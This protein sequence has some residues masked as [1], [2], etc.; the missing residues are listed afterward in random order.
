MTLKS[1]LCSKKGYIFTYEAVAVVILFVAVFYMGYFT[2]THVNLTNQEQKRDLE[3]FEKANL[4]SDMIF[5]DY[6]F[7]SEYYRDDYHEFLEDVAVRHYG[8]KKIPGSYDPLIVYTTSGTLNYYIEAEGYNS[9]A[10]GLANTNVTVAISNTNPDYSLRNIYVKEKNLYV[11]TLLDCF[12]A[13]QTSQNI[14]E[15]EILYFAINGSSKI[16]SI[17]VSSD[18]DTDATFLVNNVPYKLSLSSTEKTSEFEKVLNTYN[19][20]SFRSNEIKVLAIQ[21]SSLENITVNIYCNDTSS[22]YILKIK[23]YN[24]TLKVDMAQ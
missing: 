3:R 17:N 14:S 20:T 11:P 21:E 12:E 18:S 15:G 13:N 5:K 7:P 1:K 23:P 9:S 24:V 4:I 16:D 6:L 2:F 8:F 10:I 19:E 22:I